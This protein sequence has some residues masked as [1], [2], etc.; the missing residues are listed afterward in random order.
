MEWQTRSLEVAV[1][2]GVEVQV[3]FSAPKNR[4]RLGLHIVKFEGGENEMEIEEISVD[5]DNV[6]GLLIPEADTLYREAY[7]NPIRSKMDE[8]IGNYCDEL[9]Y[10]EY[11]R[12]IA[13]RQ[14]GTRNICETSTTEDYSAS[15]QQPIEADSKNTGGIVPIVRSHLYP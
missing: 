11:L 12:R 8:N 10:L 3:L 15:R 4:K 6:S 13:G 14:T 5:S 7:M 2:Q 1:P 9:S